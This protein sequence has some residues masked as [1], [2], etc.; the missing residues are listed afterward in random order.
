MELHIVDHA[1]ALHVFLELGVARAVPGVLN[2]PAV[3]DVL[4]LGLR[5]GAVR[6]IT[7]RCLVDEPAVAA[8]LAADS[9]HLVTDGPVLRHP[10]LSRHA[11]KRQSEVKSV[12]A[13]VLADL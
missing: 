5:D 11:P 13:L 4:Q 3:A 1:I 7:V 2:R 6:Y 9:K 10:L 8:V 12:L